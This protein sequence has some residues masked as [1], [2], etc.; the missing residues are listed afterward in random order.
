M[1]ILSSPVYSGEYS[2]ALHINSTQA[3]MNGNVYR[4]AITSTC[5]IK[6][7][8]TDSSFLVVFPEIAP[9][10]S[11]LSNVYCVYNSPVTISGTP[12][13][14]AFSGPG[15]AGNIFDPS[16]AGI[17]NHQLLYTIMDSSCTYSDTV[18][19]SVELC[20]ST[21]ISDEKPDFLIYPNPVSSM[22]NII[23][24]KNTNNLHISLINQF[25]QT[26]YQH[27]FSEILRGTTVEIDVSPLPCGVYQLHAVTS[28]GPTRVKVIVC[29]H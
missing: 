13:G 25:G 24:T 8:F 5:P 6:T 22:L 4:C 29:N 1:N 26:I 7:L 10:L 14:G 23:P 12:T 16:L 15:V 11:G 27:I 2:S 17:G 28:A 19:V 18:T 21:D 3:S 9:T 20:L